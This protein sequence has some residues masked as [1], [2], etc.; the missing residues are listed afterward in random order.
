[1]KTLLLDDETLVL[2]NLKL[3]LKNFPQIEIVHESV[4]PAEALEWLKTND[5]Q[6]IFT[7][8]SMPG[9]NGVDFAEYLSNK[10]RHIK[11]IF[12]TAYDCY[13]LDSFR[14]NTVDYLLKPVT[15]LKLDKA[16]QKLIR[17]VRSPQDVGQKQNQAIKIH[18][19]VGEKCY[20]IDYNEGILIR[21]EPRKIIL[22]SVQGEYVLH[23]TISYWE[24]LLF[25]LFWFR[26][27][28]SYLINLN[29]VVSVYPSFNQTYGIQMQGIKEEVIV[30]RSYIQ[31]LKERLRL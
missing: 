6:V 28:R 25:P 12:I 14:A 8:I 9:I 15:L 24:E 10:Y 29:K 4:D 23:N 30:S 5:V 26:C 31:G 13:A 1:M 20:I 22:C 27:H 7:D 21:T 3:L 17:S 18:G 16:I 19:Y 11:F 2:K